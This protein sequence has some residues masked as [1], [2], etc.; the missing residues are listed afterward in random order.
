M[1]TID[2]TGKRVL[3]TGG[4]RGIG[5]GIVDA[6]LA[7]GARVAVNG[8]SAASTDGALRE[9][10]AGDRVV[11]ALGSVATVE[12]CRAVVAAALAGLGGLDVLINNAGSG[13]PTRLD[14]AT[15]QDWDRV[16]DTNLKGV[17]FV[18]QAAAPALRQSKGCV[19]NIASV[20]GLVG[21]AGSSA[22][23][24]SKAGIINMTRCH[25]LELAPEVRVNAICPGGVDTDMLRALAVRIG[26]TVEAGYAMLSPDA[27]AQK[28]I[29]HVREIAGPALYLCSD[30]A[31]FVTGS[32][33]VVD[34]GETID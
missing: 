33:H 22:Y 3:V 28:R 18:T 14:K 27:A 20:F 4:S 30:L 13:G 26:G 34:G 2:M 31:S 23:C 16:V 10:R 32:V 7:A 11:A 17:F 9:L 6:F 29:A 12:G 25:A 8:S 21:V 24:A 5:R 1:T 15:E 19:V